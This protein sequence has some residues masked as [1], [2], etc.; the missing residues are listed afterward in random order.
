[1][2]TIS[3]LH[4]YPLKG[5]RGIPVGEFPIGRFGP[6]SDRRWMVVDDAGHLVTQREIA[7]LCQITATPGPGQLTLGGPGRTPL[8]VPTDPTAPRRTVRIW[9]DWVESADQGDQAA[10]WLAD[11]L[12]ASVRLVHIP[13]DVTRRTDPAYDPVGS[14]VS[15]A[16]GYPILIVGERSLDDLNQRLAVPLPMNRFRPN[17]VVT[18]SE[19]F[20]EDDWRRFTIGG[21]TFD[22]VKP[23]ARCTVTTTDQATGDRGPEPL[24]TMASF[25]KRTGGVMF[26]MNVVH[27][28]IGTVRIGDAVE[29]LERA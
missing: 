12:G 22:A 29:I 8:S 6:E 21:L 20:A 15:F 27:R 7:T 5:G 26:G 11:F 14:P 13:D 9:N 4:I 24:R 17:I 25:R 23:C 1:M 19:P 10:A 18:G 16:D 3:A 2:I 28:G